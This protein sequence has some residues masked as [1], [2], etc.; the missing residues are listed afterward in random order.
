MTPTEHIRTPIG[1]HAMVLLAGLVA[2]AQA[3]WR[4]LADDED[5]LT[6]T[7]VAVV[8]FLLVGAAIV[9]TGIIYSAARSN[10]ESIPVPTAPAP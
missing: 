6:T 1:V 4:R 8:T 7:E 10:A 5:G 3:Q 9:V 2:A